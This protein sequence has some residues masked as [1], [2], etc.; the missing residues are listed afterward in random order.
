MV[1][2]H[3]VLDLLVLRHQ[4]G[5]TFAKLIVE[6]FFPNIIGRDESL[7][8]AAGVIRLCHN[9]VV[10]YGWESLARVTFAI[11][12]LAERIGIDAFAEP[13]AEINI[14]AGEDAQ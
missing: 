5:V 4:L 7:S 10:F 9:L 3:S 11:G 6:R 12:P 8:S 13:V 14:P 1:D 2:A